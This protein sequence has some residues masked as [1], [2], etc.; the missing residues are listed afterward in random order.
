M[1]SEHLI[2]LA[3]VD[4]EAGHRIDQVARH[5]VAQSPL[6]EAKTAYCRAESGRI[7]GCQC[8]IFCRR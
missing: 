4:I 6:I 8:R 5:I 1:M 2:E 7:T 3:R